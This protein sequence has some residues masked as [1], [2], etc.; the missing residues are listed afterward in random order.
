MTKVKII[1]AR[2]IGNHLANASRIKRWDVTVSD[3]D[4]NALKRM[5][6]KIYPQRYGSFDNEIKLFHVNDVPRDEFD[7]IEV[8][9][10][11]ILITVL[12]FKVSRLTL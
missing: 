8:K 3:I 2:S 12:D 7:W 4:V 1:G 10:L 5:K 9:R 6:T 11:S